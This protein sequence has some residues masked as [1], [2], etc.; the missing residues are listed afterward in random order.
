M[1]RYLIDNV[2]SD[3]LMKGIASKTLGD[4]VPEGEPVESTTV[5]VDENGVIDLPESSTTDIQIEDDPYHLA[6]EDDFHINQ[7]S[8][9]SLTT[10]KSE[11]CKFPL[12]HVMWLCRAR[13]GKFFTLGNTYIPEDKHE[14]EDAAIFSPVNEENM[15]LGTKAAYSMIKQKFEN[16]LTD[17]QFCSTGDKLESSEELILDAVLI[18][19]DNKKEAVRFFVPM[20]IFAS[21]SFTDD[22][23]F[24]S[25]VDDDTLE[26]ASVSGISNDTSEPFEV[27]RIE[28][29]VSITVTKGNNV[30]VVLRVSNGD[31]Q[32]ILMTS[33]NLG[34]KL[35][36][37]LFSKNKVKKL[38]KSYME[39]ADEYI[40]LFQF[41]MRLKDKE[42]SYMVIKA[43]NKNNK[44]KL[45]FLDKA[46]QKELENMIKEK[47]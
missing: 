14:L 17:M 30:V 26:L 5:E 18:H 42:K 41:N 34:V 44:K 33:F 8:L 7:A 19:E 45:F 36:S 40:T 47:L 3:A 1:K 2:L 15:F 4:T 39:D 38:E 11:G 23:V 12:I 29:I 21:M 27:L 24:N 20:E 13:S 28:G 32:E 16:Y 10:K 37:G 43:R 9:L 6:F 35:N 25:E 46:I 31:H 22:Y